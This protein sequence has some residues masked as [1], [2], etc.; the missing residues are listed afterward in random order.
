MPSSG[1][2][3]EQQPGGREPAPGA[4]RVVQAF[5][6]TNDVEG[7]VDEFT[8]PNTLGKW[9][10]TRGLV[11]SNVRVT[12]EDL[13]RAI[14]LRE[15]LRALLLANNGAEP[16]RRAQQVLDRAARGACFTVRFGPQ[17]PRAS[18]EPTASGVAGALGALVAIA[19]NA[20]HD[21]TW[22]RLK[23]CRRDACRWAFYDHSNAR[24][25]VWCSMSICGNR[26]KV[27]RHRSIPNNSGSR[28]E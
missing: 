28:G 21:E 2:I 3:D 11:K 22:N 19:F 14:E 10:R 5:V 26:T 18:L 27:I 6:N 8:T 9:F 17:Q 15:A 25:G 4:L 16:D 23:A 13:T 1:S 7:G 20:I 24:S 12:T